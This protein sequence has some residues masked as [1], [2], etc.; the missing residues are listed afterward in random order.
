VS[1]QPSALSIQPKKQQFSPQIAQTNADKNLAA[2]E[3]ESSKA[4]IKTFETPRKGVTGGDFREN[5]LPRLVR[6]RV[7][8]VGRTYLTILCFL[9][10]SVFQDF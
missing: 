4:N 9:R 8:V 10:S 7:P 6:P 5:C 3:R 1:T 2:N